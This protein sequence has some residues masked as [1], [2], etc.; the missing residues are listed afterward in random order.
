MNVEINIENS[1]EKCLENALPVKADTQPPK[2]GSNRARLMRN[3][4]NERRP[5]LR[6]EDV[7]MPCRLGVL[8]FNYKPETFDEDHMRMVAE[9]K[10]Y[11][12][13]IRLARQ[14][15]Q[16]NVMQENVIDWDNYVIWR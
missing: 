8:K 9:G 5:N 1:L 4:S 10:E 12:N 14:N 11:D 6:Q 15:Q 16:E 3:W 13:R 2:G 7:G